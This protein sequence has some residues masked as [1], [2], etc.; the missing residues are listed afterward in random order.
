V[1]PSEHHILPST[2]L[3]AV[4][5]QASATSALRRIVGRAWAALH[6]TGLLL[7]IAALSYV[8][9]DTERYLREVAEDGLIESLSLSA[10]KAQLEA[11]RVKRAVLR[12][13]QL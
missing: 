5:Q 3:R 8:I 13:R 10:F 4:S 2:T 6:N 9:W 12:S 7:R 11:D 1:N